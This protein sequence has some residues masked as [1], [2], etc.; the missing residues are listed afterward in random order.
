MIIPRPICWAT[1]L[2]LKLMGLPI[3]ASRRK[4]RRCPPSRIGM[5][6]RFIIPKLMLIAAIKDR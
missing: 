5:G 2:F 4:K 3:M 1:S 6:K